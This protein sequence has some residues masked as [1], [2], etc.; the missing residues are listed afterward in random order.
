MALTYSYPDAYLGE[1]CTEERETR[2][3]A[4]VA[5]MAGSRTFSDEWTE[6]LV[7]VQTY[8]LACMENQADKEDLFTAK[9]ETY[10]KQLSVLLP[11]AIS[12]ADEASETVSGAGFFSIPLERA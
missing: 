5:V 8:I 4:D 12:A 7:I 11:Q 10:R 6:R 2:A 3:I 9:L 1:F